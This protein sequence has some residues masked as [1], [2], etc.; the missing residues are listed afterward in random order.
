MKHADVRE[1][2]GQLAE[3]TVDEI[4]REAATHLGALD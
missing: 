1:T 3:D 2:E 4:A